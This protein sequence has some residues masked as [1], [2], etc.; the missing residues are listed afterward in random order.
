MTGTSKTN[1]TNPAKKKRGPF[2]PLALFEIAQ[3]AFT[4]GRA[5]RI[6][7][8]ILSRYERESAKREAE[9]HQRTKFWR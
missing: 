2:P 3:Y 8:K 4:Y 9:S 7:Q 5:T 1:K 6:F